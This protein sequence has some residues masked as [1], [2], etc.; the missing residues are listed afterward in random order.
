DGPRRGDRDGRGART[1]AG[2][3]E[4]CD[5]FLRTCVDQVRYMASILEPQE[6]LRRIEAYA[7]DEARAGRLPKGAF[8]ILREALLTGELSRGDAGRLT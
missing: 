6:L 1:Q 5:F 8:P 3:V 2:L 4:F 7:D